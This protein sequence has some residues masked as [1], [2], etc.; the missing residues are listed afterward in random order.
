MNKTQKVY[1]SKGVGRKIIYFKIKHYCFLSEIK[2]K[3][4]YYEYEFRRVCK[5]Y[6]RK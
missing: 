6:C 5:S 4:I 3:D 1:G 2:D